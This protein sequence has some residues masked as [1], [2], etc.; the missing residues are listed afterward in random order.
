MCAEALGLGVLGRLRQAGPAWAGRDR[1]G[2]ADETGAGQGGRLRLG[3]LGNPGQGG[4]AGVN[5]HG[6]S[7][8][9]Q[10]T[11]QQG[12]ASGPGL[13]PL[14]NP[15]AQEW[16]NH[17]CGSNHPAF[18]GF[19]RTSYAAEAQEWCRSVTDGPQEPPGAPCSGQGV[20]LH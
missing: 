3:R 11:A 7:N 14:A 18:T 10:M 15:F 1:L 12:Q 4:D 6:L 9:C 8:E 2:Q 16:S 17:S 5:L 20:S 13:C 19:V